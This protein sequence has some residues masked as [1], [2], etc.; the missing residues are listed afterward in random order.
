MGIKLRNFY[1]LHHGFSACLCSIN[2]KIIV[3]LF[4]TYN[5]QYFGK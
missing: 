2:K 4:N 1:R 3:N 5:K